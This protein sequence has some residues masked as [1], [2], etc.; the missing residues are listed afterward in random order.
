MA[1]TPGIVSRL[2]FKNVFIEDALE[3]TLHFL[4]I[5]TL[6]AVEGVCNEWQSFLHERNK[7]FWKERCL[8]LGFINGES[9]SKVEAEN[10]NHEKGP[11]QPINF[12][13]QACSLQGEVY[14]IFTD[15]FS[16]KKGANELYPVHNWGNTHAEPYVKVAV[17]NEGS[18]RECRTLHTGPNGCESGAW[19]GCWQDS[20]SR[21]PNKF[22]GELPLRLFINK[23]GSYKNNGEKVLLRFGNKFVALTCIFKHNHNLP[24]ATNFA[25]CLSARVQVSIGNH[26]I[27]LASVSLAREEAMSC[28]TTWISSD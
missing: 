1:A 4:D 3:T 18:R 5:Q 6:S 26:F 12:K 25:E 27:T 9:E 2:D 23:N 20:Y 28:T 15:I 21:L 10:E 16:R 13:L 8:N 14:C 24:R 7:G 22:P 19:M 11:H 17:R